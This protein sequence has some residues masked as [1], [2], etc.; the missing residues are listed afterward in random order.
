MAFSGMGPT[1]ALSH[2]QSSIHGLTNAQAAH[3]L[4]LNGQNVL[5]CKRPPA[6]WQLLLQVIPNPFNILLALI[7]IISVV[8]PVPNWVGTLF[9]CGMATLKSGASG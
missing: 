7:A 6:W 9:R 3:R 8:N 2:L 4:K 1:S 5:S